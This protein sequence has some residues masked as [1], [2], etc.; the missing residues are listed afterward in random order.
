MRRVA[1][2]KES[3]RGFRCQE[4]GAPARKDRYDPVDDY[5]TGDANV[6]RPSVCVSLS[7]LTKA[8]CSCGI[9]SIG[10]LAGEA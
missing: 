9:I 8:W 5:I 1:G 6:K 7:R 2:T 10:L 3:G 4:F